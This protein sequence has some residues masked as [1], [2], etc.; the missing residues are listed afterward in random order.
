[1]EYRVL[2]SENIPLPDQSIDLVWICLVI[3]GLDLP[4]IQKV[5]SE[6]ERVLTPNGLLLLVENTTSKPDGQWWRYRS[7]EQY[8]ADAAFADL[9]LLH[10][11]V[12]LGETMSVMGGRKIA[13]GAR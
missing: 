1:V 9:V 4:G 7:V 13:T 3:G 8:V 11:Y 5:M 2:E 12:D 10:K 6:V